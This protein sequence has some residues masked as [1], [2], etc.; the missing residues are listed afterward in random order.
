MEQIETQATD[1]RYL[2][3]AVPPPPLPAPAQAQAHSHQQ[4]QHHHPHP[5]PQSH[6]SLPHPGP[7]P[8][9]PSAD[10]HARHAALSPHH[11]NRSVSSSSPLAAARANSRPPPPQ[12]LH[13]PSNSGP[14]FGGA[15]TPLPS[16][17]SPD[18]GAQNSYYSNTAGNGN[19]ANNGASNSGPGS[20]SNVNNASNRGSPG[21][22]AGGNSGTPS[23]KRKHDDEETTAKQQRSKRNRDS[24]EFKSMTEKIHNLEDQLESIVQSIH[25]LRQETQRVTPHQDRIL[26]IPSSTVSPSPS[27]SVPSLHK[28]ELAPIR[29]PHTF[30]GGPT[31]MAFTVDVAKNT[32]HN[33]GYSGEPQEEGGNGPAVEETPRTSPFLP[34]VSIQTSSSMLPLSS[35]NQVPNDPLWEFDK[36]EMVRLC[37]LHEDEVGIMYPVVKIETVIEHAQSLSS[38]ME[39]ARRSGYMPPLHYDETMTDIRTLTLKVIMCCG[40]AVEEHG[41][42]AKAIR[43]YDSM[44]SITDGKLMS[45]PSNLANL[46]FLALVAGYR[47]LSNDEVLAWR[48]MGQVARHCLEQGLHRRE[49]IVKIADEQERRDA[50]NTFWTAYVLDRRWSFGTG[51]PYVLHDDKIDPNLPFPDEYPYLVAMITYSRL[52]AKIWSLVDFF[53]PAI[54]RDLKREEFETLD[55]EILQWYD[56]CPDAVKISN[57][58]RELPLPSTPSYNL[59][60]LQIWTRLRLN[61]IR[62]WLNT[63]VLHS[64]SSINDNMEQAQKVVDLAKD[65]IRY[66]SRL[67]N[68]SNLYRRIQVFYHQFLTSA[69]AVL[70]LASTHQPVQFSADCREEFY[71]AMN[72]VKD[73]SAKSWVSQRLWRTIRSLTAYAPRLG[74][75]LQQNDEDSQY[76]FA[77]KMSGF[78]VGNGGLA[79]GSVTASASAAVSAP[80]RDGSIAS[81]T[82]S[83]YPNSNSSNGPNQSQKAHPPL[84]H[85]SSKSGNTGNTGN[86]GNSSNTASPS[87]T[88]AGAVA[89]GP[90][91]TPSTGMAPGAQP[92]PLEQKQQQQQQ[93]QSQTTKPGQQPTTA[94]TTSATAGASATSS[95]EQETANGVQIQTEM[96]RIYEGFLGLSGIPAPAAG[97][98]TDSTKGGVAAAEAAAGTP[99]SNANVEPKLAAEGLPSGEAV[100]EHLKN[101]F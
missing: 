1:L 100:Y 42:S 71:M 14:A 3:Q 97:T 79:S 83:G 90:P 39:S 11:L 92:Q 50:I 52:G 31:S 47:F 87:T 41:H 60:R 12:I 94:T 45:E 10:D 84:A 24:E 2:M 98:V 63:P 35:R 15:S 20:S 67:N 76:S 54:I 19:V 75:G 59:Q 78:N 43:L 23:G 22:V 30:R 17:F 64:A 8:R 16:P 91:L 62:I 89:N 69:I 55:R 38:W 82:G 5:H 33:M 34:P 86:N 95:P 99:T 93:Q 88:A 51:L 6:P 85:P 46:P 81:S 66:L 49:G 68:S 61:Q 32:L 7:Y 80:G 4:H 101:M 26:P 70:F 96:T 21:S 27:S 25:A 57:F 74:L 13:D 37:R 65:T 72:L 29:Q 44:Q 77:T 9:M 58:D 18:A 56:S 40:L 48:V 28:P 73:M 36:D 53:E